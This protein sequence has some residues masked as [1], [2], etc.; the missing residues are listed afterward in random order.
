MT[1][2]H[3]EFNGTGWPLKV[4][5]MSGRPGSPGLLPTLAQM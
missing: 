5:L 1:K 4:Q 2:P 3:R